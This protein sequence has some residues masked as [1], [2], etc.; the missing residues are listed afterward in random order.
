MK[1]KRRKQNKQKAVADSIKIK[2]GRSL[3]LTGA[4]SAFSIIMA[5][6]FLLSISG[7]VKSFRDSAFSASD[8]AWRARQA[9]LLIESN[10]LKAAADSS[11]EK[12]GGYLAAANTASNDLISTVTVLAKLK[13]ATKEDMN[14]INDL[15][16]EMSAVKTNMM[17][18][19]SLNTEDGYGK[20]KELLMNDFMKPADET[21]LILEKISERAAQSADH[22]VF[23]SSMK[24]YASLGILFLFFGLT[25]I[26]LIRTSK[27]IINRITAPIDTIKNALLEVSGGNLDIELNYESKDEFGTL[28]DSIRETITELKKYIDNIREVLKNISEKDMRN[29]IEIEYKGSFYPLKVSV[30]YIVEFLNEI[31]GKMKEMSLQVSDGAARMEQ[32]S[33]RLANDANDQSGS[34]EELAATI[35]EISEA[36]HINAAHAQHVNRFFDDSINEINKGND[37]MR[38][39]LLSMEQITEQSNQVSEIVQMIDEISTQT[40]LLSL[41]ASIEAARAGAFGRG[42]AVVAD[43]I[44]KLAKGS[45]EAARRSTELIHKTLEAVESGSELT[46]RT[47]NVFEKIVKDSE[48]MRKLV[49]G[50][51]KACSKQSVTLEEILKAVHQ[52]AEIT[53]S[54]SAAAGESAALSNELLKGTKT[55]DS[56]LSEYKVGL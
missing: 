12:T 18:K 1:Q 2:L 24:S 42:F 21:G 3:R 52:I 34:V 31:I 4:V 6:V 49:D 47:A 35:Q 43:E 25:V 7:D 23:W 44:G 10:L 39:M 22:F 29:G 13:V 38:E 9:L 17:A 37:Y 15:T 26:I 14:R 45:A 5:I 8:Y 16:M 32:S 53:E 50:I 36:V 11:G 56:M 20:V 54:N 46:N 30:N 19:A 40:D 28:A 27:S 41:N 51:D 48:E 33:V 55:L